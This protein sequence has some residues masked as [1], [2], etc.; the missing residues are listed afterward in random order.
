MGRSPRLLAQ[1]RLD[2]LAYC[3]DERAS[4]LCRRAAARRSGL[5]LAEGAVG[6]WKAVSWLE[7]EWRR[8]AQ[9][10][11]AGQVCSAGERFHPAGYE[12]PRAGGPFV[13]S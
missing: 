7:Q 3:A 2:C 10:R 6:P 9:D 11:G 4:G 12:L 1:N 5:R 13:H 8:A